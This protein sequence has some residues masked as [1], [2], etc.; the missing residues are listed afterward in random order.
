MKLVYADLFPPFELKKDSVNA[1]VIED[2]S[3]FYRLSSELADQCS[4]S[5]GNF[6]LSENSELLNISKHSEFISSFLP[7]EINNKK[8]LAKLYSKLELISEVELFDR[9][10]QFRTAADEYLSEL[11]DVLDCNIG[12]NTQPDLKT[13]FKAFNISFSD[14]CENIAEKLTEYMLN[15]LC[16]C[17]EKIIVTVGLLNYMNTEEA[18]LFFQTVTSHKITLLMIENRLSESL[19]MVNRITIDEDYCVF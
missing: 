15:V 7:F 2:G 5:D 17:G 11:C 9:T 1:I 13:L 10:N 6:V 14:D 16:L 8:L 3:L 19:S 18:K 12:Y 4:G